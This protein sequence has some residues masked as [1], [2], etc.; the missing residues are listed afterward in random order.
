VEVWPAAASTLSVLLFMAKL[1]EKNQSEAQRRLLWRRVLWRQLE[2]KY[3]NAAV[4]LD[5]LHSLRF[6]QASTSP[7]A[8]TNQ[9]CLRFRVERL[10]LFDAARRGWDCPVMILTLDAKR[11]LCIPVTIGPAKPGGPFDVTSD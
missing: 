1:P 9:V 8:A 6:S 10:E 11:C 4:P 5:R 7:R 3:K 2:R